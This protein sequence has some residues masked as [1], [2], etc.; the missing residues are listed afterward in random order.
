MRQ[1]GR[2][3][4]RNRLYFVRKHGLSIGR[5]YTGLAIRMASLLLSSF[6]SLSLS[7]PVCVVGGVPV[8]AGLRGGRLP[9]FPF[10]VRSSWFP[11]GSPWVSL[12]APFPARRAACLPCSPFLSGLRLAPLV[13]PVLS[14]FGLRF[15]RVRGLCGLRSCFWLWVCLVYVCA[16]LARFCA[17]SCCFRWVRSL[18]VL[19]LARGSLYDA[20]QTGSIRLFQYMWFVDGGS[21]LQPSHSCLCSVDSFTLI[22]HSWP[23]P[24]ATLRNFARHIHPSSVA[25][26]TGR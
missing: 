5:C 23:E 4:V 8:P 19:S 10:L 12:L 22:D 6:F 15:A 25:C 24:R 26:R 18:C 14:F 11:F 3:E 21:F 16:F 1:F 9:C 20:A 17:S 13:V 2:V 7:C